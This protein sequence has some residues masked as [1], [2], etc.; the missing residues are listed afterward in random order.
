MPNI[1]RSALVP[2]TQEQMYRLVDD[3]KSYPEFLPWCSQANEIERTEDA[4]KAAISIAKGSLHKTFTTKNSLT[5]Y[6]EIEMEL[7]DGPF[8]K[9]HGFWRFDRLDEH[10]CK[11]SLDLT[12]DFSSKMLSLTVGPLFSQVANTM[13]DSFVERAKVIYG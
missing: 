11:V 2:Y 1:Y 13:V 4:V 10:A 8:K 5:Q 9:L 12:F 6:H 7:I 3:I